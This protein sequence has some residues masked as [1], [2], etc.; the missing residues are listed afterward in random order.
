MFT[1]AKGVAYKMCFCLGLGTATYYSYGQVQHWVKH[2]Q[3]NLIEN[4]VEKHVSRETTVYDDTSAPQEFSYAQP[5]AAAPLAQ[6]GEELKATAPPVVEEK[7]EEEKK[8]DEAAAEKKEE[9]DGEVAGGV[10]MPQQNPYQNYG[11]QG[12]SPASPSMPEESA[13]AA[14]LPLLPNALPTPSSGSSGPTLTSGGGGGSTTYDPNSATGSLNISDVVALT[15]PIKAVFD[16]KTNLANGLLCA[17]GDNG[18]ATN[19]E[20]R[21][22]V[23]VDSLRWGMTQ[24]LESNVSF[25]VKSSGV[26]SVEFDFNFKI[27]N[28]ALAFENVSL[29]ARPTE[30]LVHN[31]SRD[32]KNYRII[33][34][35]LPDLTVSVSGE[36][37]K[38]V[39]A[40]MVYEVTSTGLV[41]SSG[42]GL[43]FSRS[44]VQ[45]LT[46]KWDPT[47]PGRNPAQNEVFLIA[48]D[49]SFSMNIEK[50]I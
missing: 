12:H 14:A 27:Q 28:S 31:E 30:V 19:C 6:I 11:N 39:Q 23:P 9:N 24:G 40:T 47:D 8:T 5:P 1:F 22:H 16:E 21:N 38:Q 20:H 44:K 3:V 43:N 37:L 13:K 36:S 2:D 29:T 41:L 48:D 18:Q 4:V 7:K 42:S 10:M 45:V 17:L 50:S 15:S 26:T 34:F 25:A 33:E 49:L 46:S 32:S 35:K